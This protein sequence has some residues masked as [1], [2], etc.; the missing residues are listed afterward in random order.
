MGHIETEDCDRLVADLL[1]PGTVATAIN[2][3]SGRAKQYFHKARKET[4]WSVCIKQT[5]G[6]VLLL[7]L[8]FFLL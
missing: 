7:L 8:G 3:Q 4:F 2:L 5:G 6:L 1:V